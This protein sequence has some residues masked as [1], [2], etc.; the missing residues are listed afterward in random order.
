MEEVIFMSFI[1]FA[2][3]V[4]KEAGQL[5]LENKETSFKVDELQNL[6]L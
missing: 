6:A 1:Q 5:I 2:K 4:S 3:G